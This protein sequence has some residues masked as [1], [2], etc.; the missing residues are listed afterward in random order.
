MHELNQ[1]RVGIN[2]SKTD[3]LYYNHTGI[4]SSKD[5]EINGK[6]VSASSKAT[7]LGI[8]QCPS[9]DVNNQRVQEKIKKGTKALY[10]LFG[11]G[12]HGRTGLNPVTC[13]KLWV[14]FITPVLLYGM[15]LWAL[16]L[17]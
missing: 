17:R 4:P 16:E 7:H 5:L 13:R 8:L 14:S 3:I 1:N 15:E 2:T 12:M 9:A 6:T 10:A 11:A